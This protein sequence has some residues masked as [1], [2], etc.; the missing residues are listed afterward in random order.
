MQKNCNKQRKEIQKKKQHIKAAIS[1]KK[2]KI[3]INGS[4]T[5]QKKKDSKSQFW[6]TSEEDK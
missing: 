1:R 3:T 5:I 2:R 4:R 6:N